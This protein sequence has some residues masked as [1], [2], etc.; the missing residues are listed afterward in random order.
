MNAPRHGLTGL[1]AL[2][3]TGLAA[4]VKFSG[5]RNKAKKPYLIDFT[6]DPNS[7]HGVRDIAPYQM[8]I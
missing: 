2:A 1:P 6:V 5:L 7:A 3:K 4:G 8:A